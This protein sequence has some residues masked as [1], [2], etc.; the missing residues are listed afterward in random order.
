M[1]NKAEIYIRLWFACPHCKGDLDLFDE[2]CCPET[3]GAD[4]GA[5]QM[6]KRWLNNEPQVPMEATCGKCDQPIVIEELQW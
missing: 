3:G 6:V 2:R 4:M 5:W 1:T